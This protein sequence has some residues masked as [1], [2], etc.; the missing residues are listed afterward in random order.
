MKFMLLLM[1]FEWERFLLEVWSVTLRGGAT[2]AE[3]YATTA[4]MVAKVT[5]RFIAAAKRAGGAPKKAFVERW[6][7][8]LFDAYTK[9][10]EEDGLRRKD[11]NL[12]TGKLKSE[13]GVAP[14]D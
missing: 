1:G 2:P 14:H 10:Y 11:F 8:K 4:P 7:L 6:A 3:H 5:G 13:E 9:T 12:R